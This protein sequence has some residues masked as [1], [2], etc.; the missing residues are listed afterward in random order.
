MSPKDTTYCY[1]LRPNQ[2]K[3]EFPYHEKCEFPEIGKEVDANGIWHVVSGVKGKT[4]EVTYE[5]NVQ[6]KGNFNFL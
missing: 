5:V 3:T 4:E 1:V 2:P 6:A